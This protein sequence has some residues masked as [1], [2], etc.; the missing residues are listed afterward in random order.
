MGEVGFFTLRWQ[1]KIWFEGFIS[2]N[3]YLAIWKDLSQA[4]C[5]RF[6]SRDDIVEEF[7]K[8]CKNKV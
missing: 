3:E 7:N 4:I 6:G 5:K 1:S 8:L 2:G